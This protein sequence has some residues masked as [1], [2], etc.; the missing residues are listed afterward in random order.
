MSSSIQHKSESRLSS[1]HCELPSAS[2][3]GTRGRVGASSS[4]GSLRLDDDVDERRENSSNWDREQDGEATEEDSDNLRKQTRVGGTGRG[5]QH[6]LRHARQNEVVLEQSDDE[7]TVS[8]LPR[9]SDRLPM[10][11]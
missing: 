7:G 1:P 9:R 5:Q 8:V 4:A 6:G 2:R 10:R 3:A 11:P